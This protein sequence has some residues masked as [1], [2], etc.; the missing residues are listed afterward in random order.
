MGSRT[1]FCRVSQLSL[2][3]DYPLPLKSTAVCKILR[4][5][6]SIVLSLLTSNLTGCAKQE[7]S[8]HQRKKEKTKPEKFTGTQAGS[9]ESVWRQTEFNN[10]QVGNNIKTVSKQT[11]FANPCPKNGPFSLVLPSAKDLHKCPNIS[12]QHMLFKN[13]M[14]VVLC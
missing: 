12:A 13:L 2:E 10:F 3:V 1:N 4:K 7:S 8:S 6:R 9:Y 5:S 11:N 14:F